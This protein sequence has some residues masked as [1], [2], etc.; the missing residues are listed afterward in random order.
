QIAGYYP[1]PEALLQSIA[2]TV[3]IEQPPY[4][5]N[6]GKGVPGLTV[7]DPCAG[8]GHALDVL[9]RSWKAEYTIGC[10]LEE[11]RAAQLKQRAPNAFA[12]DAFQLVWTDSDGAHLLWLNPPYD[13]DPDFRRLEHRFLKRFTDALWPG[14]GL[15]LFLVPGLALGASAK[16]LATHFVDHRCWR[17]PDEHYRAF[18][19]VL[20]VARRASTP[21]HDDVA[22]RRILG[23]AREPG[24]IAALPQR[25]T[26]P[27]VLRRETPRYQCPFNPSKSRLEVDKLALHLR[28]WN[29]IPDACQHDLGQL[30]NPKFLTAAPPRAAHVALALTAGV[31]NGQELQPDDPARHPTLLASGRFRTELRIVGATHNDK[32]KVT[33]HH[34]VERPK[35]QLTVHDP[36]THRFHRLQAGAEPVGGDDPADWTIAD[37]MANYRRSLMAQLEA[38]F[39]VLHDPREADQKLKLPTLPRS[40]YPYQ[41]DAITSALKLM[42]VGDEH[43]KIQAEMGTGKTTMALVLA[44]SLFPQHRPQTAAQLE[45]QGFP[46]AALPELSRVLVLCPPHLLAS[47]KDE[48]VATLGDDVPV[49]ILKRCGDVDRAAT[50]PGPSIALLS[51]EKAKLGHRWRGVSSGRCPRC[52]AGLPKDADPKKLARSRSRCRSES[53]APQDPLARFTRDLAVALLPYRRTALLLKTAGR[54]AARMA[55]RREAPRSLG[56]HGVRVLYDLTRRSLDALGPHL[57]CALDLFAAAARQLGRQ[58]DAVAFLRALHAELGAQSDAALAPAR[59]AIVRQGR[60]L[61]RSDATGEPILDIAKRVFGTCHKAAAWERRTCGEPLFQADRNGPRTYPLAS[62]I[63]RR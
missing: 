3:Q 29:P 49:H 32:G 21:C 60:L 9:A 8:E 5:R 6:P 53:Y 20:L 58:A 28:S 59:Q 40:P 16:H 30:L 57:G 4:F 62:Y 54:G 14:E 13:Q 17:L 55:L 25:C 2:S 35:L 43:P 47:W 56:R 33:G 42:A 63:A 24:A 26:D 45:D 1:V 10:E 23:W 31:F 52:S 36:S 7:F 12:G 19:Q 18:G 15:L 22:E 27:V 48:I 51:R 46:A 50:D 38:A 44:A 39:P 34:K 61:Q 37:L 11:G 41:A